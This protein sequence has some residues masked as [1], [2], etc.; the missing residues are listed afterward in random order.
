MGS[1]WSVCRNI[2]KCSKLCQPPPSIPEE[3]WPQSLEH[4]Q[5]SLWGGS[6]SCNVQLQQAS[7][8]PASPLQE[9]VL[10]LRD[11]CSYSFMVPYFFLQNVP[12]FLFPTEVCQL[13]HLKLTSFGGSGAAATGAEGYAPFTKSTQSTQVTHSSH[14]IH[15]MIINHHVQSASKHRTNVQRAV[16]NWTW[17]QRTP[18]FR[19]GGHLLFEAAN[20]MKHGLS[21]LI[22]HRT[23]LVVAP[24]LQVAGPAHRSLAP[25][26]PPKKYAK[27]HERTYF[28]GQSI[29]KWP[30]PSP[31]IGSTGGWCQCLSCQNLHL[32]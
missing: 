1:T 6:W 20:K 3:F 11:M 7:C 27:T 9:N 12:Y 13:H 31:Q 23:H 5:R 4:D 10:T 22:G 15:I 8:T 25:S 28:P 2:D 17:S 16:K 21:G 14:A 32:L 19:R 26:P 24:E 29:C 18:Q 30:W